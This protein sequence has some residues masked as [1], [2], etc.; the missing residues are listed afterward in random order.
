VG[1]ASKTHLRHGGSGYWYG[2]KPSQKAFLEA[3][4]DSWLALEGERERNLLLIPFRVVETLLPR[5][6]VT[7][8]VHW[9]FI[10]HLDGSRVLLWLRD[11]ADK[12]D[13]TE[14]IVPANGRPESS[15]T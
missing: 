4:S 8:G 2:F 10:L 3:G 1:L 5:L 9:H 14:Y 6:G 12:A 15:H 11:G 13:L 7:P